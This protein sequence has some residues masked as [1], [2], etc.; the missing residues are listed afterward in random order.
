MG[1]VS[2]LMR[3]PALLLATAEEGRP[4]HHVIDVWLIAIPRPWWRFAPVALFVVAGLW[5]LTLKRSFVF[6]GAPSQ[7][8]WRDLR[9]WTILFLIPYIVIY[10]WFG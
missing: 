3:I 10:L 5:V 6:L 8:A 7:A 2:G 1:L 4:W 9:I